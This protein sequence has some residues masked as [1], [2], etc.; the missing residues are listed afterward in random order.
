MRP[1]PFYLLVI[2]M[3]DGNARTHTDVTVKTLCYRSRLIDRKCICP[4]NFFAV[5]PNSLQVVGKIQTRSRRNIV[6]TN[7]HLQ[8]RKLVIL[9]HCYFLP[10]DTSML[11]TNLPS[12]T[13][14]H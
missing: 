4:C 10:G 12:T 9:P 5:S 2:T 8:L 3:A 13:F 11:P 14:G 1:R 6:A 7:R